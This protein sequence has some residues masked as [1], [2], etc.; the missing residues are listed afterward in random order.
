MEITPTSANVM[1]YAAIVRSMALL[2]EIAQVASDITGMVRDG[3][4]EAQE[5]LE[6]AEQKVYAIRRD[7]NAQSLIP[8]KFV[9]PDVL[10]HISEMSESKTHMSGLS[11]GL[12]AI[13]RKISGL[14]KSDLILLAARPG[15]G[16]TALVW[17]V[18]LNVAKHG[19][20]GGDIF[21]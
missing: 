1:E 8:L 21:T 10:D 20:D 3:V 4:G 16:K 6:A 13:D 19:K 5:I 7:L 17:N 12:S 15:M 9:L 14:N 2:R 11:T 18:A